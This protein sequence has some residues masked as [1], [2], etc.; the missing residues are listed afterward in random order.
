MK[1]IHR[2]IPYIIIAAAIAACAKASTESANEAN[3]RHLDAWISIKY[4]GLTPQWKGQEDPDGLYVIPSETKAG[5]GVEVTNNGYAIVTYTTTDLEGNITAYTDAETALQMGTYDS[6]Y[7]YGPEVWLTK[8]STIPAGVQDAIVGMKAGG[9]KK[10]IVPS[11]LMTYSTYSSAKEYL[12]TSSTY[13][14]TIYSF[15]VE[16]FTEDIN[17]WQIEKIKG[18]IN[19]Y[20]GGIESFNQDIR[21]DTTGF[22]FK[23]LEQQN[24]EPVAFKSDTTIYINYTGR[25]LNGRMF[26]TNVERTAKDNGLYSE[27]RTYGPVKI[28]WGESVSDITMNG[29]SVVSGFAMALWNL[30]DLGDSGKMDKG[31]GIFYSPLGYGTSSSG[32]SIPA[33]APLVFE[34]EIVP[35]PEE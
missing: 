10:I 23:S 25:L 5:T 19:E 1:K 35:A 20:Y 32:Y 14:N 28:Q 31:I 18:R 13:A 11:W 16:D 24:A 17:E 34:I 12:N 2:L 9:S 15:T 33:Y 21:L 7:Y 22:Y 27:G 4:P 30:N 8:D 3:K 6:T 26:D 29:S